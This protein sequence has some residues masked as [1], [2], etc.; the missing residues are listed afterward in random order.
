MV[1]TALQAHVDDSDDH[2]GVFTRGAGLSGAPMVPVGLRVVAAQ[3]EMSAEL[4]KTAQ[5]LTQAMMVTAQ[6][7]TMQM[8]QTQR[9]S[10]KMIPFWGKFVI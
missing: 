7:A 10:F 8:M 1:K 9:A 5:Q 4:M 2:A 3:T 6:A